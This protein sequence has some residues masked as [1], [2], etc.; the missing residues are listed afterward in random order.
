MS[1]LMTRVYR[2][3]E[4]RRELFLAMIQRTGVKEQTLPSDLRE[5]LDGAAD[6]EVDA[7]GEAEEAG[8]IGHEGNHQLLDEDA[9]FAVVAEKVAEGVEELR[10]VTT[11]EQ[12]YGISPKI[13]IICFDRNYNKI[14]FL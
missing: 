12:K 5:V 2:S 8:E 7:E 13:S 14:P 3:L 4:N 10:V 1:G 9:M 11:I 6:V